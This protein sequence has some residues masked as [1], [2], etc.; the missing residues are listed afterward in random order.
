MSQH[1]SVTEVAR[2]FAAFVNRVAFRGERFTLMRGRQ[3]VAEL[4]PVPTGRRLGD[5]P[6]LLAAL[7]R[8]APDDAARLAA[9]LDLARAELAAVPPG[10]PWAS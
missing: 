9:D 5:V 7:P 6:T 4:R 1:P 8:L 10:D 2:N 3:A